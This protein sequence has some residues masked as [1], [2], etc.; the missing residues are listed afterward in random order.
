MII[1]Y[2]WWYFNRGAVFQLFFYRVYLFFII[3]GISIGPLVW[4]LLCACGA[5]DLKPI[6]GAV[7]ES[8]T[9]AID[10]VRFPA[11]SNQTL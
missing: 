11:V 6:S 4:L 10:E 5:A 8:V 1:F 3:G 2:H 9:K 7:K